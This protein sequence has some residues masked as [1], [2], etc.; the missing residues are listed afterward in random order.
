MEKFTSFERVIGNVPDPTKKQIIKSKKK[1]FNNQYFEELEGLE[2]EKTQEEL[3][4]IDLANKYTNDIL[5]KYDLVTFDIP[6]NNIH[7]VRE[8][9]KFDS[10]LYNS[11]MQTIVIKEQRAKIAFMKKVVHEM[12]HFKSYSALQI[13]SNHMKLEEY[14]VGLVIHSRDGKELYL[15]N[16]NEAITEEMT[17]RIIK[18]VAEEP[19]FIQETNRTKEILNK[20]PN[21]T[22]ASNEPLFDEDTFCVQMKDGTNI[23]NAENFTKNE[24][25]KILQTL[26]DKLFIQNKKYF[27][28]PEDVFEMF[29]RA[30]M[31]GNIM[32][33]GK[34]I[35][36]TFGN[37]TFIK[38]GE[39]DSDI[40][41]LKKFIDSL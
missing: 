6:A 31:T 20:Y 10:A 34:L 28:S 14:R 15:K 27:E 16:L 33:I 4:I 2:R 8:N 11:V 37:G 26:L 12:L 30:M 25:R 9:N 18:K 36:H 22:T 1:R 5:Q 21:A 32:P 23:I 24:E 40:D 35:N 17:K 13:T 19:F 39:L 29:S 3:Q 41:K 38:I 7:V